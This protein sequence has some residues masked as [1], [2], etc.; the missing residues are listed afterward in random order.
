MN[1]ATSNSCSR[2]AAAEAKVAAWEATVRELLVR[3]AKLEAELAK[4]K[5]NSANSSKPPS[6]DVVKPPAAAPKAKGK[7]K[8]GAQ[9]GHPKHER[10]A[11]PP[12]AVDDVW[13]YQLPACPDCGGTVTPSGAAPRV[14]QQVEIVPHPVTVT[15]Y[16][17]L[18]C[19]CP[20][21]RVTHFA[22]VDPAAARAGLIGPRLTAVIAYL[23]GAGH[24]SFS[25][26][27]KFVRDVLGVTISRGHL[28]KLIAKVSQ[29]LAPA[30]E[31]LLAELPTQPRLH[32]DE[33]GHKDAGA[34]MW[35]W[36]F[37][38]SLFTL[39]KIDPSRGADVLLETLG[40]EF[41]GV[42][43]CDYFSAYRRYMRETGVLV[44][45]CL[46]HL[47]RDLKFLAEHPDARN[48]AYGRRVLGAAR[49]LFGLIH[50]RATL[51][52]AA[53]AAQL[54]DAGNM[55]WG[56]AV[57]RVPATAEAHNLARRFEKHGESYIRFVTTPGVEPTNNLAEQAIR[58]VVLDRKVTQGSRGAAGQRWLERIWTVVATCAQQGRS[59]F[60]FLCEAVH[61][62]LHGQ[63]APSL[64][65]NT[66]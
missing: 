49:D 41:D 8:R 37:R 61:A 17:G 63:P 12:E 50:R 9:L 35:T 28:A 33:T 25:T 29:S 58:F 55:L 1:E 60:A 31:E 48:R 34:A 57:Y 21:C 44:Q 54:E 59:V 14:L 4:A 11:F 6:S 51:S 7:R 47:I 23:K 26:I 38:A 22:P 36:C 10:P 30:Y 13:E 15:E 65:P 5:K 43:G 20:R 56:Q 19:Y 53:F 40:R 45:F 66:S 52:A 16:R 27:R 39:F 42:L 18:P 2:C 46:A 64:L 62:L 3:I 24:A 32:V